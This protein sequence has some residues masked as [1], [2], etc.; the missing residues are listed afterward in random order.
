[1]LVKAAPGD[2]GTCSGYEFFP[3]WSETNGDTS[4]PDARQTTDAPNEL[5]T[6]DRANTHAA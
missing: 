2:D 5:G 3:S 1:M 4:S 6:V